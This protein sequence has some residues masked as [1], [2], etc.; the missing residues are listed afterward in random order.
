VT[1]V[2]ASGGKY[3]F[4]REKADAKA[5]KTA[6]TPD[7][8]KCDANY[9]FK[10]EQAEMNGGGMCPSNGDEAAIQSLITQHADRVAACLSGACPASCGDGVVGV[11]EDCDVGTLNGKTCVTQGFA[12][13]TLACASG[14]LFDTSGCWSSR[15]ADNADGTITDRQTGL[16]W[17]KKTELDGS[18]N[19][20]NLHDADDHYQWA[21]VCFAYNSKYCQ[22]TAAASALCM[23]NAE[24]GGIGCDECTGSEGACS[25][26]DTMW[27]FAAALNS[28]SFGGHTDWR[29]P[30]RRELEFIRD[31]AVF[32]PA[33]DVAFQGASC[34][35]MCTDITDQLC[36]CTEPSIYWSASPYAPNQQA[37]GIV[38]FYDGFTGASFRNNTFSVRAVRGGA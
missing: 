32:N 4:C 20:A 14:C 29:V 9:S 6:T 23:A 16:M 28:A 36:S 5:T 18:P 19:F 27:T 10:W 37:A 2:R 33:V 22:P 8:T 1:A 3:A 13:G 34:G 15:F 24:D 25:A 30:N 7:Y 21:G 35:N 12:G 26:T 11:D 38:N 17:E 31:L